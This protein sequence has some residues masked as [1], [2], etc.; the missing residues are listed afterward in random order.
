[1]DGPS[2][3]AALPRDAGDA[4]VSG[5]KLFGEP[6]GEAKYLKHGRGRWI[7]CELRL[8]P[9]V[10]VAVHLTTLKQPQ[11]YHDDSEV[12]R[13]QHCATSIVAPAKISARTP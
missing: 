3:G 6:P 5:L 13:A 10:E 7:I 8:S 1:M 9:E 12:A 11:G 2:S 4:G